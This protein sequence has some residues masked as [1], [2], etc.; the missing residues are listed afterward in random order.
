MYLLTVSKKWKQLSLCIFLGNHFLPDPGPLGILLRY[1]HVFG[2]FAATIVG[3][4]LKPLPMG[5]VALLSLT[6]LC[7]THTLELEEASAGFPP[8]IWLIVTAFF[9]SR[10]SYQDRPGRADRFSV[11]GA[12]REKDPLF[13]LFPH[14][15][16]C[17]D[18]PGHAQ[19]HGPGG[20]DPGSHREILGPGLRF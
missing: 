9:I 6:V 4:I 15:Q 17:P 13:G 12:L 5:A 18:G 19:Q 11:C 10:A 20:R 1:W 8:T 14:C 7:L 3:L 16:R 2:I